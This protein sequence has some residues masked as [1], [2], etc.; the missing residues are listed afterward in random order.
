MSHAALHDWE[1][2]PW[3]IPPRK[4]KRRI[5]RHLA[6]EPLSEEA[7]LISQGYRPPLQRPARDSDE[8]RFCGG[9]VQPTCSATPTG[10]GQFDGPP[11]GGWQASLWTL[12][13]QEG[14]T[15]HDEESPTIF[16]NPFC[17]N[18]QNHRRE[19]APRPLRL[20]LDFRDWENDI[21]FM[22]ED[23]VQHALPI[24]VVLVNH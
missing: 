12:L 2:K 22:W 17:I 1:G 8:G 7:V 20:D 3:R 9:Y 15:D 24:D 18:H 16:V 21:K 23:L 13:Q 5:G 10:S 4:K 14:R 6:V 11:E 19:D